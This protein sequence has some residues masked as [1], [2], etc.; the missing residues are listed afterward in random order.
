M[1]LSETYI[2]FFFVHLLEQLEFVII[3]SKGSIQLLVSSDQFIIVTGSL[4]CIL[5]QQS[6]LYTIFL[7]IHSNF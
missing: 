2:L 6:F 7:K 3:T 4:G 1:K 5:T